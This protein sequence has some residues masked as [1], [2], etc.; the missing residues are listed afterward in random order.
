MEP[1]AR[2]RRSDGRRTRAAILRTAAELASV[3]GLS[4]LSV[5]RL[6]S[7]LGMSKSAVFAH[8]G[9]MEA[10]QLA[11]IE[12]AARTYAAEIVQPALAEPPGIARLARLVDAF[13]SYSERHVFPGGCFFGTT[14]VEY[15][16]RPGRLRDR[17]AQAH[18]EW[19]GVISRLLTEA[20]RDGDVEQGADVDQLAFEIA[21]LL[22]TADWV[23]NL[24]EDA[25]A[26]ERGRRAVTD[27]LA[28]VLTDR[29]RAA[30]GRFAGWPG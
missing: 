22:T 9:S 18:L 10:L 2:A 21:S 3:E 16:S 29:A 8:F 24:H 4:G 30:R 25:G 6:A 7:E 13:L 19:I 28:G 11:T 1:T 12:A 5:G 20:Q 27:R 15:G 23:Y 17:L 26:L 14:I